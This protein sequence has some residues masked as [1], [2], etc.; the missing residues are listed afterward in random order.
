[1][2][3]SSLTPNLFIDR[4]DDPLD[5]TEGWSTAL[6]TEY[7]FPLFLGANQGEANFL[8]LFWQQTQYLSLGRAGILAG[9]LRLGAIEPFNGSILTEDAQLVP[10]ASLRN[11]LV[12]PSERFFGG[13]R[14]T[15]RA[16]ARD[17]LGI[18]GQSLD[19]DPSNGRLIETGG[20]GLFLTN[21][22]YRFPIS[23]PMGGTV[24]LD[25][26][27]IWADWRDFDPDEIRLGVGLGLRYRSPIGPLRLEVGWKLD[28]QSHES[29]APEFFLSF[30]NPF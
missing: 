30:G 16:Y 26:G 20:N 10:D 15:H 8:K 29:T 7:A 11:A 27:N 23:G 21:L 18:L 28:R 9:S 24:F 3:I 4:R 2:K 19:Q 25:A 1:V 22:D 6:Q 17:E 13:G 5:P 14:T 12:P